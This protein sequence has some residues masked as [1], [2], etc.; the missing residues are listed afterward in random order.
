MVIK[1]QKKH[2]YFSIIGLLIIGII[3]QSINIY[4]K[5]VSTA[6]LKDEW[7]LGITTDGTQPTG[8]ADKETLYKYNAYYVGG[9]NDKVVFLT[10][11]SGYENGY[12]ASILDT[13][14][15]QNVKATFFLVGHYLTSAPE[16]VKRMVK[17]GH[18]VGNHTYHHPD[19]RTKDFTGFKKELTD[20]ED[21]YKK[22]TGKDLKKF[23][24]PPEGNFNETTLKYANDLG[25]TTVFWSLAYNDWN[26]N[27]QPTKEEAFKQIIPRL[28]NGAIILLHSTSKTNSE[29]LD[30]LITEIKKEGYR[31]EVLDNLKENYNK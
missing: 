5:T 18:N 13:L 7:G 6:I 3:F 1:F 31:F 20:M 10:F 15:K 11:D 2:L 22:L 29:I 9:N 25:Y 24:R 4:K 27:N 26:N 12:T 19:M 8:N 30:E 17:E 23:Y 14:K 28:H 16:M 21:E